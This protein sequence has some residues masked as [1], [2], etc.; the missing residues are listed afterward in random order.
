MQCNTSAVKAGG[1]T[2][3]VNDCPC[4]HHSVMA[5]TARMSACRL[6]AIYRN[7]C[8][9]GILTWILAANRF[10]HVGK[11]NSAV[12]GLSAVAMSTV[13][14]ALLGGSSL[15]L[16]TPG[17]CTRVDADDTLTYAI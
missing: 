14:K 8:V 15:S 13:S 9:A 12:S 3:D 16:F 6:A 2:F 7:Q 4:A 11:C 1:F 5:V 17:G 10:S